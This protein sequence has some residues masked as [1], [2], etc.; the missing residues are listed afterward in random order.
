[1]DYSLWF[2]VL[3]FGELSWA[4]DSIL[5]LI[6]ASQILFYTSTIV[7]NHSRWDTVIKG[8]HAVDEG[9]LFALVQIF[10]RCEYFSNTD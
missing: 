10:S 5:G 8:V 3:G 2:V 1:M 6:T 4:Y 9:L 7:L